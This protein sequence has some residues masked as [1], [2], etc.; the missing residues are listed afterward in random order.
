MTVNKCFVVLIVIAL[1]ALGSVVLV[2]AQDALASSEKTR[3]FK[4]Y[5]TYE[6]SDGP[7]TSGELYPLKRRV[8]SIA[9]LQGALSALVEDPTAA[10][11]KL[12]YYS[13]AYTKGMK[14]GSAKI[15]RGI[16]YA[17]Y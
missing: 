9:P 14:L 3:E 1:T 4:V 5:F 10:E 8:S 13:T 7:L 16:A 6:N 15:K 11:T 12:G 17:Y 2:S